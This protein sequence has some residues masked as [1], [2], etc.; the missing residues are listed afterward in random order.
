ME[1]KMKQ[2]KKNK[3]NKNVETASAWTPIDDRQ[4]S[5]KVP[6]PEPRNYEAD[7]DNLRNTMKK[8]CDKGTCAW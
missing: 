3:Q 7:L 1:N 2:N 4:K 8:S 6:G 5:K